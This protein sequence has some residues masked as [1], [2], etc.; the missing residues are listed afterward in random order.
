MHEAVVQFVS[1]RN[2]S[3]WLSPN[4]LLRPSILASVNL[5]DPPLRAG[6]LREQDSQFVRTRHSKCRKLFDKSHVV[7]PVH[8]DFAPKPSDQVARSDKRLCSR[9]RRAVLP[10]AHVT[11]LVIVERKEES[12]CPAAEAQ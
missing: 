7:A 3:H 6:T 9:C 1:R 11:K 4:E 12:V 10:F 2:A 5:S 8:T